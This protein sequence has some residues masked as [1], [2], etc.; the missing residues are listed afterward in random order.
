MN[1]NFSVLGLKLEMKGVSPIIG[2]PIFFG[3]LYLSIALITFLFNIVIH[4]FTKDITLA[5]WQTLVIL[6]V[7]NIIASI[8]KSSK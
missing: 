7:L 5:M 1:L 4:I 3:L 6:I 8:F 2:F